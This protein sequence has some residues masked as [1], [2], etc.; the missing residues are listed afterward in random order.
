MYREFSRLSKQDLINLLE[1][2]TL[3]TAQKKYIVSLIFTMEDLRNVVVYVDTDRHP[4][5]IKDIDSVTGLYNLQILYGSKGPNQKSKRGFYWIDN[6]GKQRKSYHKHGKGKINIQKEDLE[7]LGGVRV[8]NPL[9]LEKYK[10]KDL[11]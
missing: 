6:H 10:T 4:H 3:N 2:G 9:D 5:Y 8:N 7:R 1:S 11:K